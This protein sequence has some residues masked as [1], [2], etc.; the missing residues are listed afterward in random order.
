[1]VEADVLDRPLQLSPA[2]ARSLAANLFQ[3]AEAAECDGFLFE[4]AN[5]QLGQDDATSAQL[6]VAYRDWRNQ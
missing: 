1:M 3:A 2:E 5:T 4:F 6:L